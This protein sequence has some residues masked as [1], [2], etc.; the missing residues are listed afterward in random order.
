MP[1]TR[2]RTP[3]MLAAL[4]LAALAACTP[5]R[6]YAASVAASAEALQPYTQ[7]GVEAAL[8]AGEITAD[9]ADALRDEAADLTRAAKIA[10][11]SR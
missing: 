5:C 2:Q 4:V 8:Q 11:G 7:R 1:K 6:D 3:I 10:A 9:T